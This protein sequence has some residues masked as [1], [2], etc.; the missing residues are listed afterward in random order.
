MDMKLNAIEK[1]ADGE[2]KAQIFLEQTGV[3]NGVGAI[4][5]NNRAIRI[6]RAVIQ[7][8]YLGN[9]GLPDL[10]DAKGNKFQV[11]EYSIPA[12]EHQ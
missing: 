3:Q 1:L 4:F 2:Y 11:L 8:E 10:L 5:L 7:G 9:Q 6:Q 12:C